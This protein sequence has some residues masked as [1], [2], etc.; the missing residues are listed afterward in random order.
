MLVWTVTFSSTCPVDRIETDL[1]FQTNDTWSLDNFKADFAGAKI[2]LS[3]D[4]AHAPE[5][6]NWAIFRAPKTGGDADWPA[7]LQTFRDA[8]N[9]I[10]YDSQPQLNLSVN[11]DARDTRSFK[12]RLNFNAPSAQPPWFAGKNIRL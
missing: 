2:S 8:N 3:G 7:Q 11:G 12:I 4:I 5:F 9:R 10:H 6:S 1:R